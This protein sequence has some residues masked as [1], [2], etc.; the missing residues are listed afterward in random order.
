EPYGSERRQVTAGSPGRSRRPAVARST[1]PYPALTAGV[2]PRFRAV[3]LALGRHATG[4][5]E[6]ADD[7]R[8]DPDPGGDAELAAIAGHDRPD[9]QAPDE[10]VDLGHHPSP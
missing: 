8:A 9:H 10:L 3:A 5:E 4:S 2:T 6:G 1:S 7:D